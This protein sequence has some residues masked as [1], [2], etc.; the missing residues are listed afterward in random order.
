MLDLNVDIISSTIDQSSYD[1]KS[2][3]LEAEKLRE[4]SGTSDS[5]VVNAEEDSYSN[6][7]SPFIFDILK[8]DKH[9]LCNNRE[10]QI[11]PSPEFATKSLFPV[12][13]DGGEG[14]GGEF[15]VLASSNTTSRPQWL[16]LSFAESGGQA[17]LKVVQQKQ[18]QARKSRRGPRSRSSQ[19]RGVTFYRRT[20]RWESHIWDCGKQVYLGGFDTAHSAAKAYDRAAIKFRGVDA[21]INFV[22]SDYEEDLKQMRHLNKEEFVH[23]LRRQSNGAS[24]GNSKFRG[25]AAAAATAAAMPKIG[26]FEVHMGQLIP[27]NKLIK[28]N[29]REGLSNFDPS[30]YEGEVVVGASTEGSGHNLDLS[31]GISQPSTG[32]KRKAFEILSK[33][34]PMVNGSASAAGGQPLHALAMLSKHPALYPEIYPGFLQKTEEMA[35]DHHKRIQA[36]SSPRF[37]NWA[38]QM[39]GNNNNVTPVPVFSIAASSGFSSSIATVPPSATNHLPPILQDSSTYNLRLPFP[40]S[41]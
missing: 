38:W 10:D 11:V 25:V 16:N 1:E 14:G 41:L 36:V 2:R 18:Q 37:S 3:A 33:E 7:T 32:E 35:T 5:S 28:G 39:N 30:I 17:E 19:Y 20:G 6:N 13:G 24:R 15:G 27:G 21:D 40:T 12:T 22:L 31:L 29:G 4:D 26:P 8:K 9:G 34:R 23:V